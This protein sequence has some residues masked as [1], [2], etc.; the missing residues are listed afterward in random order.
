MN[1]IGL[2]KEFLVINK[3]GDIENSADLLIRNEL[4]TGFIVQEGTQGVVEVNS[5]PAGSLLELDTS[6]K[7]QLRILD[8]IAQS[9]Q[10]SVVPMSEIG[11][12]NALIARQGKN[13]YRL[14]R[15]F[16]GK[17]KGGLYRSLC[18]THLHI[19]R[20]AE[21]SMQYNLLQSLDPIFVLLSA[22]PY[23][24]GRFCSFAGRV[25]T[26]R[27]NVFSN[28]LNHG[29][30]L[31]YVDSLSEVEEMGRVQRDTLIKQL[32]AQGVSE[33]LSKSVYS[34]DNS[35]WGPLRLRTHTVELRGC[36]SNMVSLAMAFAAFVKG[37]N[38]YVFQNQLEVVV[39]PRTESYR[40]SDS[41][42][43]I[44]CYNELKRFEREACQQGIRSARIYDYLSYLVHIARAGLA[45]EDQKYLLPFFRMLA[46]HR[47]MADIVYM[48]ANHVSN[49]A[50]YRLC[51]ETARFVNL[52]MR[53]I[54]HSDL[55][56]SETVLH[57]LDNGMDAINDVMISSALA[58]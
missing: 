58:A 29:G 38:D 42:I 6:L 18:G 41:A 40:V 2:E 24:R 47:T 43:Y 13:R 33:A 22:S 36:D 54:Y 1:K 46:N 37:I 17:K 4:N 5:D 25:S 14:N 51:S 20:V 10:L 48:A 21:V 8:H 9:H 11:P 26:Q 32:R 56:D 3:E 50:R 28:K 55:Y 23:I 34:H 44:P 39:A 27:F 12:D 19:D 7:G 52:F 15:L 31:G 57:L 49:T 30:L 45:A 53:Q 35:T 16:F